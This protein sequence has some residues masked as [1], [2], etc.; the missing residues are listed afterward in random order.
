MVHTFQFL[1]TGASAGVPVIGCSCS[2][3]RSSKA[4]NK[5]FRPSGLLTVNGKK[6]LIDVGPDFRSQALC[7]HVDDIDG[8]ILTHTH[9]DHIAGLDDLRIFNIRK[10]ANIPCL[11]SLESFK[12]IKVRYSYLFNPKNE[13]NTTKLD[14]HVLEQDSGSISFLGIDF[15]YF[16][17]FQGGMRVTGLRVFDFAYVSDIRHFD[18]S[19]FMHLKGIKTL[20]VSALRSESS[21][22][23]F[24]IQ[25]AI[26]FAQKVGAQNTWLTHVS[27][28]LDHDAINDL[29]PMN[30]RMGFDG[31]IL[32]L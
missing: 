30:I 17:F 10:K 22:F 6:I 32:E 23:H 18:E 14:F 11:L 28:F 26:D 19:I 15:S 5:R 16:S 13:V 1:G 8:L 20:V 21:Y 31:L 25:E 27:H 29:L 7:Y 9:F 2:V 3:C 12:E 24:S 4:K